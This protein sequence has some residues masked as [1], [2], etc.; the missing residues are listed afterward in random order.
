MT[1][2]DVVADGNINAADATALLQYIVR[3]VKEL[4]QQVQ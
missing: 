1:N 2:A 4:P 3:L